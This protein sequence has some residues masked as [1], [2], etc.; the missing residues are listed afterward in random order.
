MADKFTVGA[1][2][3]SS[4]SFRPCFSDQSALKELTVKFGGEIAFISVCTLQTFLSPDRSCTY[5]ILGWRF[6]SREAIDELWCWW[7]EEK[8]AADWSLHDLD[9]IVTAGGAV[10]GVDWIFHSGVKLL[11]DCSWCRMI[12]FSL[13]LQVVVSWEK[14]NA[15]QVFVALSCIRRDFFAGRR[16]RR[17]SDSTP[18]DDSLPAAN[19]DFRRGGNKGT[20]KLSVSRSYRSSRSSRL[21]PHPLHDESG[22]LRIWQSVVIWNGL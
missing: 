9:D 20:A 8:H 14:Q 5:Q 16:P 21:S 3:A 13:S 1:E 7:V 12:V 18:R 6:R 2:V 15:F 4:M 11:K 19:A 10:A 17:R 22:S